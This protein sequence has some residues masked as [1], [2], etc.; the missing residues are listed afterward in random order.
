V[1]TISVGNLAAIAIFMRGKYVDLISG[2][3]PAAYCILIN[4]LFG[5]KQF[6]A[7]AG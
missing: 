6:M 2:F 1:V 7:L 3:C 5:Y 4:M